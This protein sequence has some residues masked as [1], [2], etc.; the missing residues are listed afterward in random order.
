MF[1]HNCGQQLKG[2]EKFCPVCGQNLDEGNLEQEET[3]DVIENKVKEAPNEAEE[4]QE[5]TQVPKADHPKIT[6]KK[7]KI[8]LVILI[9]AFGI[10]VLGTGLYWRH[11]QS[12]A[13]GRQKELAAILHINGEPDFSAWLT[14]YKERFNQYQISKEERSSLQNFMLQ[15]ESIASDDY[16]AM[17]ALAPDL[18]ALEKRVIQENELILSQEI[19]RLQEIETPYATDEERQSLEEFPAQIQQLSQQG[20]YLQAAELTRQWASLAEQTS[21]RKTGYEISISQMDLTRFPTVRMYLNIQ[22]SSGNTVMDLLPNMFFVSEKAAAEGGFHRRQVTSAVQLNENEPLSINLLADISGSMNDYGKLNSAKRI[23]LDFMDTV[24]FRVGDTVKLTPFNSNIDKSGYFTSD[25]STLTSA[26]NSFQAGGQTKLYDSIVYAVQDAFAAEGAKCVIA[27]TD[28]MDVGSYNS[29]DDVVKL[30]SN[31]DIP[32]FIVRIGSDLSQSEEQALRS[33]AEASRGSF[34]SLNE[35]GTDMKSFYDQIYRDMKQ[36]YLVEYDS[37]I[38][39]DIT[40][41]IELEVYTSN[42][43]NGGTV[44]GSI[45]PSED[46]FNELLGSYLRSY[47]RA[48]NAR[49]YSLM[50][51]YVDANVTADNK[52]SIQW[53]MKKQVSGGFENVTEE[54]LLEYSIT[55]IEKQSQTSYI[56]HAEE[57]YDTV[58]TVTYGELKT[59]PQNMAKDALNEIHSRYQGMTE[60]IDDSLT[61]RLWAVVKQKPDYLVTK[62]DDGIWRFTQYMGDLGLNQTKELYYL[63]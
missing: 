15:A 1:C 33:I 24:Q 60:M 19:S 14:D 6:K 39:Q 11:L 63:E 58:F 62:G 2:I 20:K 38:D 4:T 21:E 51:N 3:L 26:V 43:F 32:V 41:P 42:G 61:F 22:D 40:Q 25:I 27:F 9:A 46:I 53:Q 37:S 30:V 7:L 52:R 29:A 35:F 8:I 17:I 23:I 49:D 55:G 45:T 12:V 18:I 34:K 57:K 47:I 48:M 36:H 16:V 54:S 56:I 5:A 59:D 31:Y 10:S 13:N 50:E 28:G 44:N